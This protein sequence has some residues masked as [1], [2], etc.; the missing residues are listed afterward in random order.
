MLGRATITLGIDPH[1]R[2]RTA[3]THL[4]ALI[5][6]LHAADSLSGKQIRPS[7][8]RPNIHVIVSASFR[9]HV[10]LKKQPAG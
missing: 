8:G 10:A 4:S 1:S 3:N 5:H 6:Q 2:R 9:P 7:S